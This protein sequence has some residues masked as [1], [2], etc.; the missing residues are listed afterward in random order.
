M[1]VYAFDRAADERSRSPRLGLAVS[2]RV[3]NAV[4]RNRLKRALREQFAALSDQLRDGVD[5]VV[6]ARPGLAEYLEERG[7]GALGERLGEL[8]VKVA[9]PE[10]DTRSPGPPRL[11]S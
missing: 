9:G 7:S 4:V 10:N 5:I 8:A 6:I 1:V 3:G 11:G 2:R